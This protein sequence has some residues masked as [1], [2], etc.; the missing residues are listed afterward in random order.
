[1]NEIKL[2]TKI[3]QEKYMYL[4]KKDTKFL[5]IWNKYDSIME[6]QKKLIC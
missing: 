2:K 6:Y 3:Y 1:M 5:V 4:Q